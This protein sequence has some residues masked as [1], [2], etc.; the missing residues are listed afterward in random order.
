MLRVAEWIN[1]QHKEDQSFRVL[2]ASPDTL[3]LL[4]MALE[5]WAKRGRV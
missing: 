2:S 1:N 5:Q 3:P 4:E